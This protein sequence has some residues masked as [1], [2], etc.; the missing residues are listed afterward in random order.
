MHIALL[1]FFSFYLKLCRGDFSL[2]VQIDD[3]INNN[4]AR[5]CWAPTLC[6][7]LICG[8]RGMSGAPGGHRPGPRH[9]KPPWEQ[10]RSRC[11]ERDG[12]SAVFPHPIL[13]ASSSHRPQGGDERKL[14][15]GNLSGGN[16]AQRC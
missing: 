1:D 10:A 4:T 13:C 2:T 15:L 16:G 12:V 5:I 7:A 3:T 9:C 8:Y 11:W 14:E 6:Q